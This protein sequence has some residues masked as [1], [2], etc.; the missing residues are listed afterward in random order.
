MTDK[1][2]EAL[3]TNVGLEQD[4]IDAGVAARIYI[5][6][7][8]GEI[9]RLRIEVTALKNEALMQGSMY[10]ALCMRTDNQMLTIGQLK[11]WLDST[12]RCAGYK[13]N[14]YDQFDFSGLSELVESLTGQREEK[15]I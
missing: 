11:G 10:R 12:A 15:Q 8:A 2:L 9:R 5:P 14:K 3:I 6:S 7:L 4:V 1:Q 13:Q